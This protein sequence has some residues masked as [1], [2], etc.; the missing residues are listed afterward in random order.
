MSTSKTGFDSRRSPTRVASRGGPSLSARGGEGA[1]SG[2]P[3]PGAAWSRN[4]R[5]GEPLAQSRFGQ[6][7]VGTGK[8]QASVGSDIRAI[9]FLQVLGRLVEY[10]SGA[11]SL[12]SWDTTP[13]NPPGP[14]QVI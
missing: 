3:E 7:K 2:S 6:M 4:Q 10:W 1:G 5:S 12:L 11:S 9:E 8:S 13:R 14:H